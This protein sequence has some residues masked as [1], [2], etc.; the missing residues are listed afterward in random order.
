MLTSRG[1]RVPK[2][3]AAEIKACRDDA[4]LTMWIARAATANTVE[5]IF[6]DRAQ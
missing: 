6:G 2:A 3:L 1:F 5:E 4:R